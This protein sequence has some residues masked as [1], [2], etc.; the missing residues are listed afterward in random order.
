MALGAFPR[1]G[2][3]PLEHAEAGRAPMRMPRGHGRKDVCCTND[4]ADRELTAADRFAHEVIKQ[5]RLRL[6]DACTARGSF[7]RKTRRCA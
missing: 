6:R 2:A 7:P 5:V 1:Q 4:S 3:L